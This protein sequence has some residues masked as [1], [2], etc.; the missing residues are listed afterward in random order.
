M[1]LNVV[2][3]TSPRQS[4]QSF[5]TVLSQ[6][7]NT[8]SA[9]V[10]HQS[11]TGKKTTGSFKQESGDQMMVGANNLILSRGRQPQIENTA[12]VA[13]NM[14]ASNQMNYSKTLTQHL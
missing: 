3:G 10:G 4:K 5:K 13:A 1:H 12:R 6:V 7:G 9:S 8:G 14:P 11:S 2:V